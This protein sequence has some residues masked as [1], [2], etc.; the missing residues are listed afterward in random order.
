MAIPWQQ[1]FAYLRVQL[2]TTVDKLIKEFSWLS[3][4]ECLYFEPELDVTVMGF[5]PSLYYLSI[6]DKK[7]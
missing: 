7:E 5:K 4:T 6:V 2:A 3:L 1:Q